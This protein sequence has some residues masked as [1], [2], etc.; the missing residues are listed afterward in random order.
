M[1]KVGLGKDK[2]DQILLNVYESKR[3]KS[4]ETILLVGGSGD[5]RNKFENVVY[6]I[7]NKL[8]GYRVVT[9]SFRGTESKKE[10]S[11]FNQ[12]K[13]L[14]EVVEY[15]S[16]NGSR[17]IVLVCT[18]AGA[19]STAK[20]LAH[21]K[22]AQH[23]NRAIF[24]DPADYRNVEDELETWSGLEKFNPED[25]LAARNMAKIDSDVK[26]YVVNF[27]LRN[28]GKTGYVA[29]NKRG[30]DNPELFE[31]LNNKMVRYFYENTP[32]KNRGAYLEDKILPHAI[33]RDGDIAKNEVRVAN[34]IT[35]LISRTGN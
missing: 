4:K 24:L 16:R 27:L 10:H 21:P 2:A 11:L 8:P 17:K 31:R 23:F 33:I 20:I 34:I 35:D 6:Q 25:L 19:V 26:V 30:D 7:Q 15:L 9:I 13:E 5:D 18:S 12:I 14:E 29:T 1:S 3:T 32:A 28:Y 22:Y